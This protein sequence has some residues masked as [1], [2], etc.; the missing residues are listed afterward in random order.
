MLLEPPLLQGNE[1]IMYLQYPLAADMF[2]CPICSPPQSF[3][4]LGGVTR[5]LKRCHNKQV[6]FSCALCSL[7]FETQKQCKMH[8]VARR[9]CLKGTTQSPAPAPSP[10]AARR[11]AVPEPQQRKLTLQAAVKKPAPIAR[12]AERDAAIEKVPASSGN[13]TQVLASRRPVSP[14]HVAK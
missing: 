2:I 9:K 13:I 11:P 3:H 5:H 4:L 7:P 6:A 14:L 8:Q 1:D 12:P 10:P